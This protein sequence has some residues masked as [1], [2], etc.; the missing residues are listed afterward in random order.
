L[1]NASSHRCRQRSDSII[2]GHGIHIFWFLAHKLCELHDTCREP[3]GTM[4]TCQF[5]LQC[6]WPMTSYF[7]SQKVF[8][9][10]FSSKLIIIS[11]GKKL[12]LFILRCIWCQ[13]QDSFP[14]YWWENVSKYGTLHLPSFEI[15]RASWFKWWGFCL[16]FGIC[17]IRIS[18]RTPIILTEVYRGCAPREARDNNDFKQTA[19]ASSLS[20]A[21]PPN[22]ITLSYHSTF[23]NP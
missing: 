23:N 3:Q 19:M 11:F 7:E 17:R 13:S 5:L 1:S 22:L 15:G 18:A 6:D 21:P 10:L 2:F 8:Y 12:Q 9:S 16:V 14:A 20:H 4:Y